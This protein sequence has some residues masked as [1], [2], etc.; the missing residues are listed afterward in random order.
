MRANSGLEDGKWAGGELVFFE[1]GNF[2]L[3]RLEQCISMPTSLDYCTA[4]ERARRSI[5][6]GLE[7]IWSEHT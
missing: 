5:Q 7:K 2:V 4:S 1:E 6:Q 3:A